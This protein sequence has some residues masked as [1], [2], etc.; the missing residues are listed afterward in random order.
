MR[1]ARGARAFGSSRGAPAFEQADDGAE[2]A[3]RNVAGAGG[4]LR[5]NFVKE[6]SSDDKLTDVYELKGK[7][8]IGAFGSVC[9]ATHRVT[10][11]GAAV[12]SVPKGNASEMKALR[13]EI[14]FLKETDHPHICRLYETF[15]DESNVYLV[16]E[17]CSG[18]ELWKRVLSA[19][20][21]GLGYGERELA[22]AVQQM[23]RALAYCHAH[24]IVHRDVKPQNFLYESA[25][26]GAVLK[27]V[28]FGVS[29]VVAHFHDPEPSPELAAS[30]EE[31]QQERFLTRT[32]GTDGYIA[33]E[34]LLSRPYGVAADIFSV[35]ATMHAAV[36]GLPPRWENDGSKP[37][38]YA[39]PG[40]MRWRMLP[41]EAQELLAGLLNPDPEARL[42][43]VDALKS[44]WFEGLEV[45]P[46]SRQCQGCLIE[47]EYVLR[48]RKFAKRSKLQKCALAS[49]AAFSH[50]HGQ[51]LESLRRAFLAA[52]TDDSGE[53]SMAEMEAAL[54]KSEAAAKLNIH[55]VA[56]GVDLSHQG[57][58]TF[59]EFLAAAA[60][61]KLLQCSHS[62][63]HAFDA[64][65]A[66]GDGLLSVQDIEHALHGVMTREELL[67]EIGSIDTDGD[68]Q[69]N[70][71]EFQ[72]LLNK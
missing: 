36:V 34:V 63:Q 8:G 51:E 21:L 13:C 52:D 58:I 1:P 66:D 67:Q 61:R 35:G 25:E 11:E 56:E 60:S 9:A 14:G 16:M 5:G 47:E 53:V 54:G 48:M 18:G 4:F 24:G 17:H 37:P 15:E 57:S 31:D 26:E 44:P 43:A 7:L 71:E 55:D 23:L 22:R 69:L 30:G 32:V 33:P 42:T 19:H 38:A 70:F 72:I 45:G 27:L 62:A 65:D 49:V 39:F 29:G 40:K 2:E 64:L 46:E 41:K 50:I 59:S 10:G 28:D 20:E 3:L 68:G 6:H 12:K